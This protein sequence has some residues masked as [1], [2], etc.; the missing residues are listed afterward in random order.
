MQTNVSKKIDVFYRQKFENENI[1]P[2]TCPFCG[3][4]AY[5]VKKFDWSVTPPYPMWWVECPNFG[6]CS[7]PG[8]GG[9]NSEEE[10]V[11]L[12]NTRY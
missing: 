2:K 4:E 8:M 7:R 9:R 5:I 10:A 6:C 12:W 1:A 11:I 3:S